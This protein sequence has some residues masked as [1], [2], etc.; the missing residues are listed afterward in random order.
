MDRCERCEQIVNTDD[1][2]EAY[3]EEFDDSCICDSCMDAIEVVL[4]NYPP[5]G[6]YEGYLIGR[7]V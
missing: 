4:D 5:D 3:R 1:K 7:R 2:P 6:A